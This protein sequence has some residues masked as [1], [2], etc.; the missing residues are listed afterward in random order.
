MFNKRVCKTAYE[1]SVPLEHS[2]YAGT[3][4]SMLELEM[5]VGKVEE[6]KWRVFKTYTQEKV[7]SIAT[8]TLYKKPTGS[9]LQKQKQMLGGEEPPMRAD[10]TWR[11]YAE[12]DIEDSERDALIESV[13]DLSMDIHEE[14]TKVFGVGADTVFTQIM[15]GL[16]VGGDVPPP[17]RPHSRDPYANLRSQMKDEFF[18]SID[19]TEDQKV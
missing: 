4:E 5:V 2:D 16:I 15:I 3:S 18:D 7:V 19:R 9:N 13:R 12:T 10:K 14:K 11:D 17:S 1:F 8:G 6:R